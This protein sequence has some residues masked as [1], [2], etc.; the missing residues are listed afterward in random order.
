MSNSK[1]FNKMDFVVRF[2]KI[3]ELNSPAVAL[4]PGEQIEGP[5]DFLSQFSFLSKV[6]F[7]FHLVNAETDYTKIKFDIV[8]GNEVTLVTNKNIEVKTDKKIEL[9]KQEENE[10]IIKVTKDIDISALPFDPKTVNWLT[11]KLEEIENACKYLNIDIST[12][13]ELN[14]KQKKWELIKQIKNALGIQVSK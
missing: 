1:Y 5:D 13:A 14:N 4:Q 8:Q 9:Q 10:S 3:W 12:Y 2:R 11:I 7:D 6:P